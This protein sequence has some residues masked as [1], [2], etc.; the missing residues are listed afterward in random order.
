MTAHDMDLPDTPVSRTGTPSDTPVTGASRDT[1]TVI[2]W[3]ITADA[4]GD[5]EAAGTS[6]AG[7]SP[8]TS[9][10][11][12]HL[13][14]IYSDIRGTVI[15]F[16]SD[17]NLQHAAETAGRTY[18]TITDAAAPGHGWDRRTHYR[19]HGTRDAARG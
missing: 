8:L 10:L 18:S 1:A 19:R 15:D 7:D 14:A 13:V 6:D 12:R 4:V 5:A 16:D 17:I 2:I 11:A 9:R 3:R